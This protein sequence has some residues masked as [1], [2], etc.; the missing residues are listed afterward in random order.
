LVNGVSQPDGISKAA[1]RKSEIVL[2][3]FLLIVLHSPPE[4]IVDFMKRLH[5]VLNTDPP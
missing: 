3:S 4:I 2:I 5:I 1:T